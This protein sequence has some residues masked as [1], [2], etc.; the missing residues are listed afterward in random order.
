MNLN[1]AHQYA[2]DTAKG[3]RDT[4]MKVKIVP[5]RS[6]DIRTTVEKYGNKPGRVPPERW[7]HVTFYPKTDAHREMIQDMRKALGWLCMVFDTGGCGGER[8]WELD[9]S[10]HLVDMPDADRDAL[11]DEVEG[12]RVGTWEAAL[13]AEAAK[14]SKRE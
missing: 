6:R 4:G 9:W 7:F 14:E 12:M 8:D 2:L 13:A 3:M 5:S 1:E 11:Q 10:F